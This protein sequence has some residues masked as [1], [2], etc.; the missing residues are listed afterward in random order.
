MATPRPQFSNDDRLP[1][2]L[3]FQEVA[4]NRYSTTRLIERGRG[5]YVFDTEGREYIE[6]TASFYV[7]S[8]GYQH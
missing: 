7:A 6:A 1:M 8:L 4:A 3:G 5:I 2:L